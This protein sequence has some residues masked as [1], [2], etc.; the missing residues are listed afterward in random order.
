MSEGVC[1]SHLVALSKWLSVKAAPIKLPA[2]CDSTRCHQPRAFVIPQTGWFYKVT[3]KRDRS[4]RLWVSS[5][6]VPTAAPP[7]A[8]VPCGRR[9]SMLTPAIILAVGLWVQNLLL[10]L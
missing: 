4:L 3:L 6:A 8:M 7:R 2:V 9:W 10:C 5:Q 1:I